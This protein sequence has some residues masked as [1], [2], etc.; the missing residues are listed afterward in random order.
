MVAL[1]AKYK[2]LAFWLKSDCQ[3]GMIWF[4][5]LSSNGDDDPSKA[6][7]ALLG[8]TAVG[9]LRNFAKGPQPVAADT[10]SAAGL[11]DELC[12]QFAAAHIHLDSELLSQAADR[13]ANLVNGSRP[14]ILPLDTPYHDVQHSVEVTRCAAALLTAYAPNS[15]GHTDAFAQRALVTLI[16][17]LFHDTGY[18]RRANESQVYCGA[19][20]I[21]QHVSRSVGHTQELLRD[22]GLSRWCGSAEAMIHCTGYERSFAS[23]QFSCAEDQ[24][25]GRLIGTADLLAQMADPVYPEKVRD[26]LY[27]EFEVAGLAGPGARAAGIG[28]GTATELLASTP[29][30]IQGAFQDRL[31]AL[32][33]GSY[34]LLG[35]TS[36]ANKYLDQ[37]QRNMERIEQATATGPACMPLLAPRQVAPPTLRIAALHADQQSTPRRQ[38]LSAVITPRPDRALAPSH[39]H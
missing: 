12:A 24:D 1:A 22:L 15:T 8:E 5:F 31:D 26:R 35:D 36:G 4:R 9:N 17:A 32:F 38:P 10:Y 13:Y 37:I 25:M 39:R 34:R 29:K 14:G 16:C 7:Q 33:G 3:F 21:K 18:L 27:L 11:V 20:L 23:L 6:V 28:H 2:Y 19:Q 30:F